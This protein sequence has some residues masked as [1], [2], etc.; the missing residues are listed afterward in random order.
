M[1]CIKLNNGYEI[2]II[3]FGTY[4]S[5]EG[6]AYKIVKKAIDVG[7]RHFDCAH[8]YENEDEIGAAFSEKIA[9]GTVRRDDLYITTKLWNNFHAKELI[10]PMLKSQLKSLQLDYVDLYLV[11]WPFGFKKDA[12]LWPIDQGSEAYSDIDY[13]ETWE[14]ME[15]CVRQGL[16]RSIGISNFNTEQIARLLNVAK[17]KPAVNQIEV[18]P[19]IN[20]KKLIRFCK[21]RD[22]VVTGYC[23]LG[24]MYAYGSQDIPK[25]TLLDDRVIAIGA[26]YKKTAAQIIL[27]YLVDLGITLVP[28]STKRERMIENL[29]VFDFELEPSDV[30]YLDSLDRHVRIIIFDEFKDHK[31]YPFNIE[32]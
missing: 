23:P 13:L 25:P 22:I 10:M 29:N 28:K 30:E 9:D 19:N 24:R 14:G 4:K 21:D 8:F 17:I 2:P 3:G 18:N 12:G 7:Y 1:K 26:K 15:E 27:R 16:A 20:Q 6:E 5:T 31:Y 11:H 32:Y